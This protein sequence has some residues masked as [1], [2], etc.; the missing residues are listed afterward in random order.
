M[1]THSGT[2]P[3]RG[4]FNQV[5]TQPNWGFFLTASLGKLMMGER[6]QERKG[7]IMSSK[8]EFHAPKLKR[9][10]VKEVNL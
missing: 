9:I 8:S 2:P 10:T 3:P 4:A 6:I 5:Q 1:E 7:K